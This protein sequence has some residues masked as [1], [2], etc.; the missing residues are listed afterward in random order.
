MKCT[1]QPLIHHIQPKIF[2]LLPL[3]LFGIPIKTWAKDSKNHAWFMEQLIREGYLDL[4]EFCA[5][6]ILKGRDIFGDKPANYSRMTK[7]D[8]EYILVELERQWAW[9]ASNETERQKHLENYKKKIQAFRKKYP[10]HPR[11]LSAALD[12]LLTDRGQARNYLFLARVSP[13]AADKKK[14][15]QKGKKAFE[16]VIQDFQKL[17]QNYD[18]SLNNILEKEAKKE[19][20]KDTEGI[21]EEE[22]YLN[23]AKE[24]LLRED[25]G[26]GNLHY[27]RAVAEY[28]FGETCYM[29]AKELQRLGITSGQKKYLDM[30][31]RSYKTINW[32]F[33]DY[34]YWL[35]KAGL[36]LGHI[37]LLSNDTQVL[38]KRAKKTFDDFTQFKFNLRPDL[39]EKQKK[40]ALKLMEEIRLEAYAGLTATFNKLGEYNNTLKVVRERMLLPHGK[41]YK[42]KYIELRESKNTQA[43]Q[44]WLEKE[45]HPQRY[46]EV[47]E[48][49]GGRE[50]LLNY[51]E[52]LIL[53]KN[54]EPQRAF[55]E[56]LRVVNWAAQKALQTLA[57]QQE[58]NPSQGPKEKNKF[59]E[60]QIRQM[61]IQLLAQE[62]EEN[63][64]KQQQ[65]Q[66]RLTQEFA[67]ALKKAALKI[68]KIQ[69]KM[70]GNLQFPAEINYI[71]AKGFFKEGEYEKAATLF[72]KTLASA[73]II[74][75]RAGSPKKSLGP[76]GQRSLADTIIL[77]SLKGMAACYINLERREEAALAL[78]GI[79]ERFPERL[80]SARLGRQALGLLIKVFGEKSAAVDA[81]KKELTTKLKSPGFSF[82]SAI[83]TMD[84]AQNTE[85]EN[86]TKAKELWLEAKNLFQKVTPTD[87]EGGKV[88]FFGLA[89]S[90]VGTCLY[91]LYRLTGDKNYLNQAK[92]HLQ[93]KIQ[94]LKKDKLGYAASLYEL[95]KIYYE[96]EN[97]K[98]VIQL[99]QPF[100]TKIKPEGDAN[101]KEYLNYYYNL[102]QSLKVSSAIGAGELEIA[103]QEY[104]KIQD[105]QQRAIQAFK[106]IQEFAR[107]I[108]REESKIRYTFKTYAML[109]RRTTWHTL[110]SARSLA[111]AI[112]VKDPKTH[113]PL[114]MKARKSAAYYAAE[115]FNYLRKN[116]K[117]LSFPDAWSLGNL[118][119]KGGKYFLA[120]KAF[121]A[122]VSIGKK[123]VAQIRSKIS[124]A[125]TP[126][127]KDSLKQELRSQEYFLMFSKRYLA[128]A[129]L[130][131]GI[132]SRN[133]NY[134]QE[135]YQGYE[136]LLGQKVAKSNVYLLHR[137]LEGRAIAALTLARLS[138]IPSKSNRG[139]YE[140]A[141]IAFNE[142]R[143]FLVRL[144]PSQYAALRLWG[145]EDRLKNIFLDN[146]YPAKYNHLNLKDYWEYRQK[147]GITSEPD[148]QSRFYEVF[149]L[150]CTLDFLMNEK[151]LAKRRIESYK[152]RGV[153]F[154]NPFLKKKFLSLLQTVSKE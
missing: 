154:G 22:D 109:Y 4:A 102:A 124:K 33:R 148:K 116:T 24:R 73:I 137:T 27:R 131:A 5:K 94:E 112:V 74:R 142:F 126:A 105:P 57:E 152:R 37:Y 26:F 147:Q 133:Q 7:A 67:L 41:R 150:V 68:G 98:K 43:L 149:Y 113:Q 129:K 59:S 8:A 49:N 34:P 87:A 70:K 81:F 106:L 13:K 32:D 14:Y 91:R 21:Y 123:R 111:N 114:L 134:L 23:Q 95:A 48:F 118:L 144:H 96:E 30:A 93:N 97:F 52:A 18:K 82:N 51:A 54:P 10:D 39:P 132:Q 1:P 44:R 36:G 69:E 31:K 145:V 47:L 28:L 77:Y 115:R 45:A 72:K 120:I 78:Y 85:V 9:R 146:L 100:G 53:K 88:W 119:L 35:G 55:Q 130:M 2:L 46:P 11:S 86:Q 141:R 25:E 12:V 42:K 138:G 83:S 62:D 92:Q 108:Q 64:T 75:E 101:I 76:G 3:L 63:K 60:Q 61:I 117:K 56:A 99:L 135:A 19:A 121:Q 38:Q 153:D 50:A 128:D 66:E 15:L 20:E 16:K 65:E 89:Q 139:K 103:K 80:E 110:I 58:Q 17:I 6:N 29:Y 140:K 127:K 151:N 104:S 90:Y 79:L 40:D 84:L 71:I 125:D 143:I 107:F 122:A 136:E